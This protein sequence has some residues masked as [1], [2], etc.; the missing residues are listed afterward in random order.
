MHF[1]VYYLRVPNHELEV[2][3]FIDA[4]GYI[5]VIVDELFDG[6]LVVT[7]ILVPLGHELGEDIIA[8]HLTCLKLR[9]LSHVVCLGNIIELDHA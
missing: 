6:D 4:G 1:K 8:A 5:T 3:V 9:V 7:H 2:V